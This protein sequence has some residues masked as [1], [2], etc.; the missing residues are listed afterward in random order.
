MLREMQAANVP[1]SIQVADPDQFVFE[2]AAVASLLDEF[3]CIRPHALRT[4]FATYAKFNVERYAI[5]AHV[6]Y[7]ADIIELGARTGRHVLIVLQGLSGFISAR[8]S[9]P[10]PPRRHAGL[11]A[12]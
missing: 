12:T 4:A 9:E 11:S 10:A 3:S 7:A 2:P 5:P 6:R 8:T 1:V